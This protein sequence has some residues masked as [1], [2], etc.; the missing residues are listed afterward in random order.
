M[1]QFREF[2]GWRSFSFPT[3]RCGNRS[4]LETISDFARD[5]LDPILPRAGAVPQD[6]Q[7]DGVII[8]ESGPTLDRFNYHQEQLAA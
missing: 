1:C 6:D 3:S 5:R 8:A 4:G 2:F 7:P